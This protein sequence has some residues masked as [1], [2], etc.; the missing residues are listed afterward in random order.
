MYASLYLGGIYLNSTSFIKRSSSFV[1]GHIGFGL[2][3]ITFHG[4]GPKDSSSF[5]FFN[6]EQTSQHLKFFFFIVPETIHNI[7]FLAAPRNK[8]SVFLVYSLPLSTYI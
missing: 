5:F 3:L 1:E 6:C 7:M 2:G 4:V 8:L